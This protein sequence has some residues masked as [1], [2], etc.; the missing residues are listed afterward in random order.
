MQ[1][2]LGNMLLPRQV[3]CPLN[4]KC[5][6]QL[7]LLTRKRFKIDIIVDPSSIEIKEKEE[8]RVSEDF[9]ITLTLIHKH[10]GSHQ[11]CINLSSE[12]PSFV[13]DRFC[14]N[15]FTKD[16][17]KQTKEETEQL[18]IP[19]S[20]TNASAFSCSPGLECHMMMY[21]KRGF[22]NQCPE[23]S[24]IPSV[25]ASVYVFNNSDCDVCS[26]DV[27]IKLSLSHPG[28]RLQQCLQAT[29]YDFGS[30]ERRCYFLENVQH[31]FP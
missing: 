4:E 8:V 18:F 23:V 29:D 9:F 20:P 17:D 21:L 2:L 28:Q 24:V 22:Y 12:I 27:L 11:L 14:C 26:V 31:T 13:T 1:P 3:I 10:T 7:V 25:G 30:T 5:N 16:T 6:V 19:P 15:I